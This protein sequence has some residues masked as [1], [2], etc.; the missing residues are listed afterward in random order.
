MFAAGG[1]AGE[2]RKK[3]LKN[4]RR[5]VLLAAAV[6]VIT[7]IPAAVGADDTFISQDTAATT[8]TSVTIAWVDI[9]QY[10]VQRGDAKSCVVDSYQ[11]EW[12][13]TASS[14]LGTV[15]LAPATRWYTI[16]G[17]KPSTRYH[18]RV[19]WTGS[20]VWPNGRSF[21]I[22]VPEDGFSMNAY[23]QPATVS[24][25]L[26]YN[27]GRN[28]KGLQVTWTIPESENAYPNYE[29]QIVNTK[30]KVIKS[31]L[32]SK[33]GFTL[34]SFS[35][36]K[37]VTRIRV[38]GYYKFY[39][40]A[41]Q[42]YGPWSGWKNLVPQPIVSTNTKKYGIMQNGTLKL[43]WSRVAGAKSYTVYVSAKSGKSG[44]KKVATVKQKSKKTITTTINSFK[45]AGFKAYKDYYVRVIANTSKY[46]KSGKDY[47][48]RVYAY[49]VWR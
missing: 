41:T 14:T 47:A 5:L 10:L 21:I 30:G 46:G 11:L 18:V 19:K 6:L 37:Q 49:R 44:F 39:D 3:M 13:L 34:S 42:L 24:K 2:R 15:K 32:A 45:G 9:G 23:T 38:R 16:T 7:G 27:Y 25:F 17:L 31:G 48:M 43:A 40:S 22:A 20:G 29:Y 8:T 1:K 33:S 26:K 12:G 36:Y 4:I 35:G 28:Q